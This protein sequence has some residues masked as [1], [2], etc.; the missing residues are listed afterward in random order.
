MFEK[1]YHGTSYAIG[2]KIKKTQVY[3]PSTGGREWLGEG[4][5][6]F[7]GIRAFENA[8][9]WATYKAKKNIQYINR[10]VLE[11]TCTIDDDDYMD[12]N[13]EEWQEIFRDY[14]REYIK[15]HEEEGISIQATA[16]ELDCSIINDMCKELDIKAVRQQRYIKCLEE[17]DVQSNIP[18][19][20]ILS[21]RDTRVLTI[22]RLIKIKD[23]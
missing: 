12:L 21:V 6:F 23:S 1:V 20:S 16:L 15:K 3:M 11:N 17:D 22:G 13:N 5:Y 9:R 19:C 2:K 14:K 4:V 10:A 7:I 18:N 8:C